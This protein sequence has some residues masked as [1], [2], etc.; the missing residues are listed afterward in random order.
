MSRTIKTHSFWITVVIILISSSLSYAQVEI[1]G[2]NEAEYIYKAAEDSL[3]HY[4]YNETFLRLNYNS[5]EVGISFIAELPKYDQFDTIAD[6]HPND[7]DYRWDDR[8]IQLNLNNLRLRAGSFT[9]FF[10]AGIIM[11][12]YRDKTYDHDTRLT[13]LNA[14]V[15]TGEW[16]LKGLYASLPD[17]NSSNHKDVIGGLDFTRQLFGV[18]NI[19]L[20]L[21]SQQIRR[22]DNRYSTRLTAGSR[23]E[24]ITDYFDLYSEYAESKS[25]RSVSGESRGQ[26]IYG[27][28]NAYINRFTVTGGYKKFTRFDNRLNDLPTLNSSEEPLSERMNPG[29]DEEGLMGQVRFNPDF[30]SEVGVTYSEAWNSNFSLRQSDLFVEGR[31]Y[32]DSFTLG[33]EYAQLELIDEERQQWQKEITP[34]VLLDFNLLSLPTHIRTELGYHEKVRGE[35][36]RDYYNPLL[37]FDIFFNRLSLSFIAELELEEF[38]ELSDAGSWLGIELTTDIISNTDL[39]IFIGEERGGKVCRSGV[40]YYTTPFK[41]L[42]INLTTRF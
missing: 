14:Q 36:S 5:I 10:G 27:L 28:A 8:Y 22:F 39:K 31:K 18:G 35:S 9:E 1:S 26:A 24:L 7:I 37:Q 33:L 30:T 41:G 38:S 3:S 12:S 21:T 40:C 17:E 13:G 29:E 6:L 15:I 4:F 34:A 11:R 2:L 23:I 20:S 42:R 16:V 32:Y 19:G 25:Y